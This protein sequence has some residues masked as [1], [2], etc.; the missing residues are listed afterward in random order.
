[1]SENIDLDQVNV[2]DM[3]AKKVLETLTHYKQG[4]YAK[5]EQL[6]QKTSLTP[7]VLNEAVRVLET[8]QWLIT[9][10]FLVIRQRTIL[11]QYKSTI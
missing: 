6:E 1:M 10:R 11:W 4:E 9:R 8:S 5:G 3:N 7:E 2:L